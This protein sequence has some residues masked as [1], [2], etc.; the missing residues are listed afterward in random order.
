MTKF[1]PQCGAS[2]PDTAKF[3]QQCGASM[4]SVPV[5][6]NPSADSVG[7]KIEGSTVTPESEVKV[8]KT[9]KVADG[10]PRIVAFIIDVVFIG[11]FNWLLNMLFPVLRFN[12]AEFSPT[13]PYFHFLGWNLYVANTVKS[14]LLYF[15]YFTLLEIYNKGQTIG[16]ALLGL[17]SVSET[18]GAPVSG[19]QAVLNAIMKSDFILLLIDLIVG[20]L[21]QKKA[22]L[23]QIRLVQRLTGVVIIKK[24][25]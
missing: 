7:E 8:H 19:K 1:C 20:L 12:F 24:N 16:K 22:N 5:K 17:Q 18:N 2:H 6:E 11:I 15:A 23:K 10:L 14:F 25:A 4:E 21:T 13:P 3:C 9:L